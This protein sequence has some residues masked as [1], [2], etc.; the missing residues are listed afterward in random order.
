MDMLKANLP[1]GI[2]VRGYENSLVGAG[3]VLK[4][5]VF[6]ELCLWCFP[7]TPYNINPSLHSSYIVKLKTINMPQH[8]PHSPQ[9]PPL[10]IP[11][12]SLQPSILTCDI[13]GFC[14]ICYV[15]MHYVAVYIAELLQLSDSWAAR[16]TL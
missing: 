14:N 11:L 10:A 5:L 3:P 13:S 9:L 15:C 1:E 7:R 12:T 2:Y 6:L 8:T 16:H 4:I